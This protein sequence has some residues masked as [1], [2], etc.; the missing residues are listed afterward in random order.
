MDRNVASNKP[1]YTSRAIAR[2]FIYSF[3]YLFRPIIYLASDLSLARGSRNVRR[4]FSSK[5]HGFRQTRA[6]APSAHLGKRPRMCKYAGGR[7]G[8]GG[9]NVP[10][11]AN[12]HLENTPE[13]SAHGRREIYTLRSV[14][15]YLS[16]H[17]R[18]L[19]LKLA[20]LV[21]P[22]IELPLSSSS[23]PRN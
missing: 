3:I 9:G 19:A 18:A 16:G 1:T 23:R 5:R 7:G 15:V 8:A 6:D 21:T 11:V 2:R 22:L 12:M 20:L 10:R 14:I 17:G 13:F 4:S